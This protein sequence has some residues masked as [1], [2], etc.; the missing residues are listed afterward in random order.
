[1][2]F[3]TPTNVPP[4]AEFRLQGA[5]RCRLHIMRTIE[6]DGKLLERKIWSSGVL[7]VLVSEPL[8]TTTTKVL[9]TYPVYAGLQD[10]FSVYRQNCM[11]NG[12]KSVPISYF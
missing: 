9:A 3:H 4:G 12:R 8:Q 7:S 1:M 5:P 6:H 10:T 2:H 11:Y